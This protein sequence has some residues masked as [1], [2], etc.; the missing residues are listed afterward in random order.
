M[1]QRSN[2]LSG[3]KDLALNFAANGT[4]LETLSGDLTSRDLHPLYG[5]KIQ[6][7][8]RR[9]GSRTEFCGQRDKPGNVERR[10]CQQGLAPAQWLKAPTR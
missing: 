2:P 4:N 3:G 7:V 9:E 10:S 5:A 1:A 6:P 8:E